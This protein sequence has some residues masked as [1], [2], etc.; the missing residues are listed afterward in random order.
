MLTV[1][2][3]KNLR[4]LQDAVKELPPLIRRLGYD[5][6][7]LAVVERHK[8]GGFH[9]HIAVVSDAP[10]SVIMDV[11]TRALIRVNIMTDWTEREITDCPPKKA[12]YFFKQLEANLPL[13]MKLNQGKAYW[14]TKGFFRNAG[15]GVSGWEQ[16]AR[17]EK[18]RGSM[19]YRLE[20][21]VGRKRAEK[22]TAGVKTAQG[23]LA[24]IAK[25]APTVAAAIQ[26]AMNQPTNDGPAA[27]FCTERPYCH[28]NSHLQ[29]IIVYA[30]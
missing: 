8:T 20:N 19:F 17:A 24:L 22:I 10:N 15:K 26:A 11:A 29:Q 12:Q 1:S 25:L 9:T 13:H 27:M 21:L 23:I 2:K 4:G 6:E 5:C 14:A 16:C 18:Y 28:N 7:M 30:P 3:I